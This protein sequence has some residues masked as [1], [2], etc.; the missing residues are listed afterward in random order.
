MDS[1]GEERHGL[2]SMERDARLRREPE[3]SL[4]KE[5]ELAFVTSPLNFVLGKQRET[6]R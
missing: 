2:F 3:R 5:E 6:R 4:R 1:V